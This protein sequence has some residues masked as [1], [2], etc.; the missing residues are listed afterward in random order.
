MTYYVKETDR[1][2][3]RIR[4]FKYVFKKLLTHFSNFTQK[5]KDVLK[6][7]KRIIRNKLSNFLMHISLLIL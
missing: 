1:Y 3:I 5:W 6:S 4:S 7:N 2:D